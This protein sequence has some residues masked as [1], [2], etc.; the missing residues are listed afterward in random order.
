[1]T[2]CLIGSGSELGR[3]SAGDAVALRPET[4]AASVR[5]PEGGIFAYKLLWRDA[6][7]KATWEKGDN[8]YLFVT[9][10]E[11]ILRISVVAR[12]D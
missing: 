8:R 1:M 7:G 6:Q 12:A 11:G 4:Q 5:L 2:P 3:W 10:G 9:P